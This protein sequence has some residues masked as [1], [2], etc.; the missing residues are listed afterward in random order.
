ML[1]PLTLILLLAISAFAQDWKQIK[2]M[3]GDIPNHPGLTI[4]VFAAEIARGDDLVKLRLRTDFPNGAPVDLFRQ[5]APPGFDISSISR[6]ESKLELNCATLT[7]KPSNAT[8]D[9]YQFNGKRIKSKEPPFQI[10]SGN[11]LAVY[12]CEQG[13]A[14]KTAPTLKP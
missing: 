9:V 2:E 3:S 8:A 1:K 11:I 13:E 7:V 14:P 4:E 12:F 6:I 10:E 5:S